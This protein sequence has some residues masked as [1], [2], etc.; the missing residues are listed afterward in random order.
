MQEPH[1]LAGDLG[2]TAFSSRKFPIPVKPLRYP[3][4]R[5]RVSWR[6]MNQ[7]LLIMVVVAGCGPSFDIDFDIAA[8]PVVGDRRFATFS[9]VDGCPGSDPLF[10]CPQQ[11]PS[12]A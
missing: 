5:P 9:F 11:L 3:K 7:T 6:Y 10:G 1:G 4:R 8:G 2:R 12:F